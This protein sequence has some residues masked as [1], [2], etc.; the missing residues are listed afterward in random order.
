MLCLFGIY[1]AEAQSNKISRI[2]LNNNDTV[3]TLS[4][5]GFNNPCSSFDRAEIW[6]RKQNDPFARI[7]SHPSFSASEIPVK[8][9]ILDQTWQFFLLVIA[10][11]S[12]TDTFY[13]DTVSIDISKPPLSEIDSVSFLHFSQ[14]L[15]VGW[16]ANTAPDVKGYRIYRYSGSIND[17]IGDTNVLFFNPRNISALSAPDL[18]IAAYDS[19]NLYS[20]ISAPHRPIVL[21]AS[22]MS[23][24]HDSISLTWSPYMGWGNNLNYSVFKSLNGSAYSSISSGLL[25]GFNDTGLQYGDSVCYFVRTTHPVKSYSSSSNIVCYKKWSP[26]PDSNFGLLLFSA[27]I[28][29]D[30][31]RVVFSQTQN[32]DIAHSQI[33]ILGSGANESGSRTQAQ[34]NSNAGGFLFHE[35][36]FGIKTDQA[37]SLSLQGF[38]KCGEPLSG[39]QQTRN[40]VLLFSNETLQWNPFDLWDMSISSE[41]N[42]L[43][44]ESRSTWNTLNVLTYGDNLFNTESIDVKDYTCFRVS[45]GQPMAIPGTPLAESPID[46]TQYSN[47]VC[48]TG[49]LTAYVPSALSLGGQNNRLYVVGNGI[50]RDKSILVVFNRWGEQLF[51]ADLNNPWTP[52]PGFK[53]GTYFYQATVWGFDGSKQNLH[54]PIYIIE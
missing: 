7:T 16:S 5:S 1:N 43:I 28:D 15:I 30:A 10:P 26:T 8:L 22:N 41:Q 34:S 47:I 2:C 4:W 42:I 39:P 48:R 23:D 12:G 44:N 50:D 13:S 24:C 3:A 35:L 36:S 54:G 20:P 33:Q 37:Y 32:G 46:L 19:C 25:T 31:M 51:R 14:E 27:N 45:K 52:E 29:D 18:S 40:T 21:S 17:S 49:G 53:T 38:D 11:C 6:G 9:N